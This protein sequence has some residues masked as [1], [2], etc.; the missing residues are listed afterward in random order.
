[1]LLRFGRFEEIDSRNYFCIF[2]VGMSRDERLAICFG[3]LFFVP[4]RAR[5]VEIVIYFVYLFVAG[6]FVGNALEGLY[7][8]FL[9]FE[10]LLVYYSRLV[11]RLLGN[12]E[13]F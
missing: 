3:L 13:I 2:A 1:M 9:V 5:Q 12:L 4:A 7:G 11:E 10:L 6:E 8:L